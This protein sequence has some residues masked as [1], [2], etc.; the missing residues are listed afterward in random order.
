MVR[1]ISARERRAEAEE[2]VK[3]RDVSLVAPGHP[4]A[5]LCSLGLSGSFHLSQKLN[6]EQ[7]I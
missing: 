2:P 6:F 1:V 3:T 7:G 5:V 4:L